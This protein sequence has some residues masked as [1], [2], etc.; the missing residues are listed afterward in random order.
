MVQKFMFFSFAALFYCEKL[1]K[2]QYTH[3]VADLSQ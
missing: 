3:I 2:V 1:M